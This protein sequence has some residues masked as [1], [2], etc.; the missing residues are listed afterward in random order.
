MAR[1]GLNRKGKIM[2]YERSFKVTVE[3]YTSKQA[4][5]QEYDNAFDAVKALL[6][7]LTD[8]QRM[9]AFGDYCRHCGCDN[10]HCQCANDE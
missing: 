9:E 6:P 8:E 3:R 4:D 7:R 2:E 5:A 1:A 10:P